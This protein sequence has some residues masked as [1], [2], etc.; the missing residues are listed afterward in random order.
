MNSWYLK[1]ELVKQTVYLKYDEVCNYS[2]TVYDDPENP[3]KPYSFYKESSFTT[4]LKSVHLNKINDLF[5]ETLRLPFEVK[6]GDVLHFV[7]VTY[8]TGNTFGKSSGECC[9]V[10]AHLE[11]YEADI[12]AKSIEDKT[13][14]E[15][16][17]VYETYESWEGYFERLE[18]VEVIS[19]VV[20]E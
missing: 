16:S 3:D 18:N 5:P 8:S 10:S 13:Y 17:T 15:K 7:V 6:K 9:L 4:Y 11:E 19:L 20:K 14:T 2:N 1:E 12:I